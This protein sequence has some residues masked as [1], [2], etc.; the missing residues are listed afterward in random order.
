MTMYSPRKSLATSREN[1]QNEVRQLERLCRILDSAFRIPGTKITFG[2][3]SLIGLIPGLGDA[4]TAVASG[5]IVHRARQ[6]GV[7]KITVLRMLGNIGI[8]IVA[9][10]VPIVGDLF[11]VSWKSNTRNLQL[12]EVSLAKQ[13]RNLK[14]RRPS[15]ASLPL[16]STSQ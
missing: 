11:D 13:S 7:D 9:G 12:L 16:A 10:I 15:A 6:L 14:S 5:Y 1:T 3:D 2:I 8:D 4:V